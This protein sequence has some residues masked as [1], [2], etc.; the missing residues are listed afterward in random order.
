MNKTPTERQGLPHGQK[1]KWKY[2]DKDAID[3]ECYDCGLWYGSDAWADIS[4]DN[5]VWEL[6]SPT[7]YKGSGLLC[8]NCIN[9]RLEFLGLEKVSLKVSSGPF[10]NYG[11]K[12]PPRDTG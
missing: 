3:S 9:R 12:L 8:F 4:L 6:I 11:E 5:D 7:E 10:A 2:T 1:R